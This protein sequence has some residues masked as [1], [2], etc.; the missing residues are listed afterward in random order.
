MV[1]SH[2]VPRGIGTMI[3]GVHGPSVGLYR[4]PSREGRKCFLRHCLLVLDHT[5][6]AMWSWLE[7]LELVVE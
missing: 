7:D 3:T 6:L 2:S 1:K 4:T 5:Q